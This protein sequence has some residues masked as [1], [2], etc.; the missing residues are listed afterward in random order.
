MPIINFFKNHKLLFFLI[1]IIL[2]YFSLWI[3]DFSNQNQTFGITFSE[4]YAQSLGLNSRQAYLD[5]LNELNFNKLRLI[6]YWNLIEPEKNNFNFDYLD[7]QINE[8][9]KR[10]K[11]IIL[12]IGFRVPRWPECHIPEWAKNLKNDEFQKELFNYLEKVINRYK[13][14]PA[15]K[16]WQ[17]E[18]EPFLTF[19]GIC[20]KPNEALFNHE[21]NFV[22][23][24][25]SEKPILITDSGELSPW[26]N[27]IGKSEIFGTTLYRIV[28]NKYSGFIKHFIPPAAY[29]FRAWLVKKFTPT[30]K[31]IIAELQAEPWIPNSSYSLEKQIQTFTLKDLKNNI[32]FARKT[33]IS[34]IYLWGAEWWYLLKLNNKPQYW[35]EIKKL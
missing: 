20:P 31:I 15:V 23:N 14:S 32:N 22:K 2:I 33:G 1:L 12:A 6:A 30:K 4:T 18:N 11:E 7:F 13:N 27:T 24:L 25:D 16:I 10:N 28:W 8:A 5:I 34:E 3:F 19:F 26:I 9:A 17:V 21:L 35:E 29:S